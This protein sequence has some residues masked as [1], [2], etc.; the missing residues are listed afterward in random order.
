[1]Q[2]K[3]YSITDY[4]TGILQGQRSLLARAI[5]LTES[6]NLA[7]QRMAREILRALLPA[8]GN[9]LRL[10]ITGAPGVGKSTLIEA[11]GLEL[12]RH[13][14]RLAILAI[15][16]S[17]SLS[18]G[19]ILGDKTRMEAL[20]R[21]EHCFIRPS[22][23][24]GHLGGVGRHTREAI[25]LCEAAGYDIILVETVGVGQSEILVRSMVDFFLLV[26][27]PGGGDELQG[28]KKGIMEMVDAVVMNKAEGNH[29]PQAQR[30]AQE[31]QL[32]LKY[33]SAATAG[34]TPPVLLVSALEKTGISE[35]WQTILD[36]QAY[37]QQSGIWQQRRQE[38]LKAWLEQSLMEELK[39][40]FFQHPLIKAHLPRLQAEVIQGQL[41]VP[42][43]VE[44]LFTTLSAQSNAELLL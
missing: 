32:A 23:T 5:T 30:S 21:S 4:V 38:Q 24:A 15:D 37:T 3:T 29:L 40:R 6:K 33:L 13:G 17:S 41:L 20:S 34:W 43:A 11:L 10:G 2:R 36:F 39:Q 1:M 25:L 8:S 14:H 16:P 28:L 27:I 26:L 12:L 19:S 7:H 9:S 31:Y 42:E 35:L 44:T 18:H 22:P